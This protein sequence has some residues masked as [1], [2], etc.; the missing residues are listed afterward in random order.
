MMINNHQ[1]LYLTLP[2]FFMSVPRLGML[3]TVGLIK[4]PKQSPEEIN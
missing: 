2:V 3:F 4:D 1:L